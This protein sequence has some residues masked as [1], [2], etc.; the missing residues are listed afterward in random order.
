MRLSCGSAR[1]ARARI[2]ARSATDR[3]LREARSGMVD[4]ATSCM[5][6]LVVLVFLLTANC[7]GSV[8][9]K[10]SGNVRVADNR[11]LPVN[12]DVKVV[13]DADQPV[14]FARGSYWLF[15]DGKWWRAASTGGT[16]R[17]EANPP[18]PV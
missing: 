17:Y 11:L 6:F 1:R 9:P 5:R 18:V 8:G 4:A 14:F 13:A 16:W 10:L 7:G 15:N 12:P 2:A 3:N